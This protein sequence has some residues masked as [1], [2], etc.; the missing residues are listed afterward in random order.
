MGYMNFDLKSYC[1]RKFILV[2]TIQNKFT[3]YAFTISVYNFSQI[4]Y[5]WPGQCLIC[6]Q[7]S[8]AGQTR[9]REEDLC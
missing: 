7:I 1:K 3:K 4:Y 2:L 9:G 8:E 5:K 6:M